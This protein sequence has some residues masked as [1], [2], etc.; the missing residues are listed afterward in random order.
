MRNDAIASGND[1]A[2]PPHPSAPPRKHPFVGKIGVVVVTWNIGKP[3]LNSLKRVQ[4][5]ADYCMV[6][7]N[8]SRDDTA[9][10]V[11]AFVEE[12]TMFDM[13]HHGENNFAKAQNMG[14]RACLDAGCTWVMLLDHDSLPDA[15]M[16]ESMH[17]AFSNYP[18]PD[19]IGMLIPN[20]KD[21]FS[22]RH[23]TYPRH[24]GRV[25]FMKT[26]FG[27]A[28]Y[29]DDVMAAIAS[30][31]LIPASL[32]A[33]CGMM[34]EAFHIDY[35]DYDFS[36]RVLA[37]G[38]KII[39]V[40]DALLFHQL[41]VATDH[42]VAQIR[43][44]TT[45]HHATR[46]YTIYRNRILCWR[47]HGKAIPAFVLF[48]AVAVIYDLFKII[49]FETEKRAKLTAAWHGVKDGFKGKVQ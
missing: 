37:S 41:G 44:T 31:A 16:L 32:F 45:N 46:R 29:M 20:L 4:E 12:H 49:C 17:K 10:L 14:I 25:L 1:Y 9:E 18:H 34:N 11:T 42:H 21:R 22:S 26:G 13:V 3:V 19:K 5:I 23:A 30:G 6:I 35:V 27:A 33:E 8:H 36:L 7:D 15:K 43:V 28:A 47:K 38:K 48:D 40:K 39:A 2:Q 24:I